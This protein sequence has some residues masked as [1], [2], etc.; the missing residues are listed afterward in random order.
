[1]LGYATVA[2]LTALFLV[3]A[4][5]NVSSS[6]DWMRCRVDSYRDNYV[7][8]VVALMAAD[9][10]GQ[11]NILHGSYRSQ[12]SD[13]DWT[14]EE[15]PLS[16][17]PDSSFCFDDQG[18]LHFCDIGMNITGNSRIRYVSDVGGEWKWSTKEVMDGEFRSAR[19]GIDG[20]GKPRILAAVRS[21]DYATTIIG[22]CPT[23]D[24][25]NESVLYSLEEGWRLNDLSSIMSDEHG[26]LYA[27]SVRSPE[28]SSGQV[29][30]LFTFVGGS[31]NA[32]E[33]PDVGD[34]SIRF[35]PQSGVSDREGSLHLVYR[36]FS[37]TASIRYAG[38][39]NGTWSIET[40]YDT[41]YEYYWYRATIDLDSD[42]IP[43]VGYILAEFGGPYSTVY[44][45]RSEGGWNTRMVDESAPSW[46]GESFCPLAVDEA[47]GVH[48]C[49]VH[50]IDSPGGNIEVVYMT[51]TAKDIVLLDDLKG[52][53][54]LTAI[55]AIALCIV[56]V[57]AKIL[58]TRRG[59]TKARKAVTEEL[60]LYDDKLK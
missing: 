25:W 39:N 19:I 44:A 33:G 55:A 11:L 4:A 50:R 35:S 40:I 12:G 58:T 42:G 60:G 2:A 29:A 21:F 37:D 23:E 20:E 1:M 6:D 47:G 13:R 48:L 26:N 10:S 56:E 53:A 3:T 57:A 7:D 30:D 15:I 49:V 32:S 27:L 59:R 17:D 18:S 16:V 5:I 51:D 46:S 14:T 54:I 34:G 22:M 36:Q 8:G 43:Y 45:V 52:A 31:W 9:P 38:C 41:G 24:D 28:P